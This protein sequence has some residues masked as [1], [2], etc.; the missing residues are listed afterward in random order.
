MKVKNIVTEAILNKN[1]D[2]TEKALKVAKLNKN[3]SDEQIKIA[4][5]FRDFCARYL[6]DAK[7]F[8]KEGNYVNAIRAVN[9]AHAWLDAG[10]IMGLF[11]VK[12][13]N[14]LFTTD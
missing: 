1:L 5:Q 8:K 7:H 10:A 4:T 14:D 13:R 9:Y 12:G 6:G 2:I 11:D 3:L